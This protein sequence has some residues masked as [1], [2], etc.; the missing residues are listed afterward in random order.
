MNGSCL[1]WS[2]PHKQL[3]MHLESRKTIAD[4][5]LNLPCVLE[6]HSASAVTRSFDL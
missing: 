5:D 6:C 3:P 2:R 1:T 4:T